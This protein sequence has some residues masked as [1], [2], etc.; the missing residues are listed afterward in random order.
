MIGFASGRVGG[1]IE[2][3]NSPRSPPLLIGVCFENVFVK[4]LKKLSPRNAP[5]NSLFQD[6][7][8]ETCFEISYRATLI[9]MA[10]FRG[11]FE[12]FPSLLKFSI[13]KFASS[14]WQPGVEY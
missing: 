7:V 6:S 1:W 8:Q 3:L 14:N 10:Q 2:Y 4:F 5:W 13:H 9:T 12:N 11:D